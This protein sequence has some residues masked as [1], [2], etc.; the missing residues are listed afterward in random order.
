[1]EVY[2]RPLRLDEQR[3]YDDITTLLRSKSVPT[4]VSVYVELRVDVERRVEYIIN[5]ISIYNG[6]SLRCISPTAQSVVF[7]SSFG[8]RSTSV[9]RE[10]L[11]FAEGIAN[12]LG[13]EIVLESDAK[14][15]IKSA[16]GAALFG[17]ANRTIC[18]SKYIDCVEKKMV[19]ESAKSCDFEIV[20]CE[21]TKKELPLFDELFY[22]DHYGITA[23]SRY[24]RRTYMSVIARKIADE[25][26]QP[27]V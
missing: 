19:I 18:S 25:M 15:V 10:I 16:A 21:I 3:V 12:N 8:L 11:S 9:R 20:E 6:Y 17:V 27:W 5:E 7:E 22:C 26:T 2:L 1:M 24:E 13:G 23:I 4:E 14:G